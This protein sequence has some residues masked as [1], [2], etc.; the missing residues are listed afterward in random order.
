[1]N[2][3]LYAL[4]CTVYAERDGQILLLRRAE[5]SALAG[6]WYLPG[7]GADEGESPEACARRELL[8]ES[9][10]TIDGDLE[11]V[12]AYLMRAYGHDFVNVS[13]RGTAAGDVTVSAEHT[14]ARWVDPRRMRSTLTDEFLDG[15]GGGWLRNVRDDLDRYLARRG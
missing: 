7:G 2:V 9:G 12:G 3:P 1:M 6:Q 10:L 5:G 4:A 14:G 8:E 13:Y 11:V 15:L